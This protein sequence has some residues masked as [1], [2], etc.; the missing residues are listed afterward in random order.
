MHSESTGHSE[1]GRILYLKV[2]PAGVMLA[3]LLR[4]S[5][6]RQTLSIDFAIILWHRNS[7]SAIP[8]PSVS[9]PGIP[10]GI[11]NATIE[12]QAT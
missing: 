5:N 10:T 11:P 2:L 12:V 4:P 7:L 8:I 3:R 6:T 1:D 9:S